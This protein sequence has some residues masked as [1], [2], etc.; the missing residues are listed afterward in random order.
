ML[1]QETPNILNNGIKY[2]KYLFN[3]VYI[4]IYRNA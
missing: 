4:Y 2:I 1:S 3:V